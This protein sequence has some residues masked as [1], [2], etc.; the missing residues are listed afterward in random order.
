MAARWERLT[1]GLAA[2]YAGTRRRVKARA[3]LEQAQ[4]LRLVLEDLRV[5]LG[6]P[7][8]G[9]SVQR[10]DDLFIGARKGGPPKG[11]AFMML[12]RF[13]AYLLAY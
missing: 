5:S 12:A 10:T 6:R 9:A 13:R 8:R 11:P 4:E 1:R 2:R 7:M 3:T